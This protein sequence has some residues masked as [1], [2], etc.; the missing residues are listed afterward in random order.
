MSSSSQRR[1]KM[2]GAGGA[3]GK[4]AH[5]CTNANSLLGTSADCQLRTQPDTI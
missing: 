5:T 4:N 1:S 3:A 2:G